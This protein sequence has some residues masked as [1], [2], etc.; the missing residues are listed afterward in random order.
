LTS[1]NIDVA[2]ADTA[3][4]PMLASISGRAESGAARGM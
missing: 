1:A 4:F 2:A 3:F